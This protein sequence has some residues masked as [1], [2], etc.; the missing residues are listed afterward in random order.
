MVGVYGNDTL[1]QY[2]EKLVDDYTNTFKVCDLCDLE[3]S[4]CECELEYGND[5]T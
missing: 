3:L 2:L 5:N 4:L 1:D